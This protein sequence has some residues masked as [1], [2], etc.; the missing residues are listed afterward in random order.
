MKIFNCPNCSS[1]IFFENTRCE[2][3]GNILGYDYYIDQFV[4]PQIFNSSYYNN[5]KFCYNYKHSVCNWLIDKSSPT[6]F[7]VA[8]ELNRSIPN[9]TDTE[10]FKKWQKLEVAKH[11]LIY[12]LTKLKLPLQSKIKSYNGIAFDFLSANNKENRLTGH[13]NGVITI[14]LSEADSVHREQLKKQMD[15]PYRTLLGHFR[16]EI[17]HYYY[18]LLIDN[19]N[20]DNFRYLFGNEQS[21]YGESLTLYY[22]YGAPSYWN[23][24]YISKYASAHPWEDWAETW[25]HYLHIMD[26]LETANALGIS[27]SNVSPYAENNTANNFVNP[28]FETNFKIIFNLSVTLTSAANSLNRSMGLPD[29]YP[30]VIPV[31]VYKKLEFIHNLLHNRRIATSNLS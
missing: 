5:L 2:K 17:G 29:T 10:N 13:A 27:F 6:K 19:S 30:F 26:T 3:C 14:L 28:Y 4:I 12:Q 9:Q 31:R 24:N 8:C 16:H 22:K 25:A 11:R 20:I 18:N 21:D 1:T 15:E 23:L 7:C